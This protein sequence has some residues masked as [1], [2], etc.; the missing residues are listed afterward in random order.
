MIVDGAR[1]CVYD[2]FAIEESYFKII[3]PEDGQDIEF[4][5][6]FIERSD[7]EERLEILSR[8][9][10]RPIR[11]NMANGIHGILFYE[12]T[13]KKVYYPDK[14]DC[15]AINPNGST[16]RRHDFQWGDV[17]EQRHEAGG[18]CSCNGH[19]SDLP[20]I[21]S[22]SLVKSVILDPVQCV[23]DH[24]EDLKFRIDVYRH[25]PYHFFLSALAAAKFPYD[26]EIS[27]RRRC[28]GL[29]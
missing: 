26:T 6:D 11:K 29:G 1:N 27:P 18:A 22:A 8:L 21:G 14:R 16:L 9:W 28:R 20:R 5:G 12:L 13:E 10:K 3:F 23:D 7:E 19:G 25:A 24:V 17:E 4:I 2:I 15:N